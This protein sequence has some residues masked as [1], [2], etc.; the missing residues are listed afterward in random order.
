MSET[1]GTG[2]WLRTHT[3][4]EL[5]AE[6][7]G[8]SVVLNGWVAKRRDLGSLYFLRLRDRYGWTQVLV[9]EGCGGDLKLGPEYAV[10]VRGTVR[11]RDAK[12]VREGD[13]TGAIEV[14]AEHVEVLSRSA[15]P[16]VP[17]NDEEDEA[18]VEARLKHRY[19]DL[20]RPSMQKNLLH[21]ARFISAMRRAFDEQDFADIETPILT[22]ATPE[23][24]RDYLVP[25]RVH[26]GSFYALPQSPQIFK[27]ILMVSGFDRYYQVARCFRDEDLRADRQPEFTQLDMEMSFVE[28]EQVFAVWEQVM[29]KVWSETMGQELPTP[30]PRLRWT[31]A[32]ERYGVD[33]PDTRFGMELH[34]V[35]DWAKDSGFV[36]FTGALEAGGRVLGIS[37]PGGSS[38]SRKE[39]NGLE[40]LA[41]EYGAKGL[42]WWK[43]S[44]EGGSGPLGRF[45][46]G[47]DRA[48]ALMEAL[49]AQEGDLCL[50]AAGEQSMAWR[51]LG[52][53][54]N[55]LGAKLDLIPADQWNFLWVTHFPMFE[56]I[57]LE[58]GS[59][60]WTS[61]HHPFTAPEDWDLGGWSPESGDDFDYGGMMSRA[62]DMVLNGWEL[63][64]GSVRIHR[65]DVQEKIFAILGISPEDQRAKFGFLLDALAHGA[66]PH[67]GFAM[68]LDRIVA[69]SVG[70]DNLRDMIAFPKTTKAADLMCGAPSRVPGKLLAEIHV[71]STASPSKSEAEAGTSEA[72][73]S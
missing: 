44:A 70:H 69:L 16:P 11:A 67:A 20:R 62:Y 24:A 15:T 5:R 52:E 23:G 39:I 40:E 2:S 71:S 38:L 34:D 9:E 43:A 49:G 58:D 50:F 26:P 18:S 64:S 10:S 63:G 61:L 45:V 13:A 54:R 7:V 55:H 25:S 1:Q 31:E 33:K 29:S 68:G 30:F 28:E 72:G 56:A 22:K 32:M 46:D 36:V 17:A 73:A 59:T 6:H 53:L 42:A 14:V 21:R 35:A 65:Q 4:G 41:K 51:V 60:G 57:E 19:L 3:C 12:D 48:K 8:A 47:P 27:Q 66:P 37:A